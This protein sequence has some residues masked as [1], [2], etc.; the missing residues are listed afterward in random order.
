[1]VKKCNKMILD[2]DPSSYQAPVDSVEE[3]KRQKKEAKAHKSGNFRLQSKSIFATFPKCQISKERA[4]KKLKRKKE[5]T[6]ICVAQE[7]HQDGTNHL[8]ALMQYEEKFR[9]RKADFYDLEDSEDE[10]HTYHGNYQ[11]AKDAG[12]VRAYIQKEGQFIEEGHFLS[13]AQSEVQKRA[14]ENKLILSTA[15][16]DLVNSGEISIYSYQ[17]LRTAKNL[18]T[19]DS[20]KVPDY[21]PKTCYWIYGKT[22]IG[23]SRWVR[24]NYP[25][26]FFNKP[27]NKWWDGYNGEQ[28]VLLDDFDLRGDCLGH[29][30]KI[31]ADCYSFPA[32]IKGGT[33]KPA[34]T[35]FII[36]SQYRPGDIF[37]QGKD[38]EKWDKEMQEAIERRFQIKTIHRDGKTLIDL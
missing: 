35:H 20:L 16:P 23:K 2:E 36:T 5:T 27:Q 33:I 18:Y 29:L 4:L 1:M 7:Q 22:G 17:Q 10:G 12:D 31:W 25:S 13:N 38:E 34:Y 6:Y 32:E 8:H 14:I 21:M 37:C 28:I 24:D 15:L 26:Q 19:L 11:A 9:T 3:R 30:L